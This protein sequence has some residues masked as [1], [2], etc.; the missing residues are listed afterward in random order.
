VYSRVVA[1]E[2]SVTFVICPWLLTVKLGIF[3]ALPYVPLVTPVF[4]R[5][6]LTVLAEGIVVSIPVP[7]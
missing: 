3:V 6:K 4:A 5:E 1:T 7:P 2:F